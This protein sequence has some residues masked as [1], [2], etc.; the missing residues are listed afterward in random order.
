MHTF[1][2]EEFVFQ[3]EGNPV[4]GYLVRPDDPA[5]GILVLHAWWGLNAFF[6][7]FCERL[8]GEGFTVFAPDLNRGKI[9]HTIPE[10][11]ALM[12]ERQFAWTNAAVLGSADFLRLQP[13][14]EGSKLGVVGFS[15]G[16]SWALVLASLKPETV[17]AVSL[18]YGVE[19]VDYSTVTAE[20][21]GHFAETDEW[22]P[23]EA[24][25]QMQ[26]DM[27]RA[28]L[29]AE[30]YHYP[31][32]GHWFFEADRP[33]AYKPAASALAWERTRKFFKDRIY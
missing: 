24:V 6:K 30:F 19:G 32:T 23:A 17:G 27:R 8:A 29:K 15:M 25:E 1:T 14:V 21:Q 4:S 12:E 13:G 3:A 18:Y 33:D 9:A 5:G 26:G 16:G 31:G 2:A 28:G 7:Q 10:A 20:F 11:E 22:T